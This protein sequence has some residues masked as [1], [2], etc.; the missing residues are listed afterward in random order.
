M[1]S[2]GKILLK[3]DETSRED[4]LVVP[5]AS[6]GNTGSDPASETSIC[7]DV[8]LAQKVDRDLGSRR[9]VGLALR[10]LLILKSSTAA[11]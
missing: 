3:S 9:W 2:R 1:C 7:I 10:M 11:R 6:K 5:L 8:K 4:H